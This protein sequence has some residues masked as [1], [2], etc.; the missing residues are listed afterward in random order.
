MQIVMIAN[1]TTF[2]FNL[3]RE[4]LAELVNQGHN[5]VVAGQALNFFDELEKM[6]CGIV[7]IH[8]PRRGKNPFADLKLYK[9]YYRMLKKNRPSLVFTNNIKPN[10]YAGLA[11]RQLKIPYIVNITGLG[12]AVETPGIMQKITTKLY[13]IGVS[14]AECVF[15]QN[16]QNEQF[17][18]ERKMLSKKS[19]IRLLPGSG[20]N[21]ES[22]PSLP[23]PKEDKIHFLFVA[24]ILKEKGIDQYLAAAEAI[25]KKRKDVVFH[26]C[27]GC[28]DPH[29]IQILNQAQENEIVE[30][31]GQQKDM[32]PFFEQAACIVHPSYYP[33]GMSNVLLEAAAGARP[34]IATNRSGCRETVDDGVS[35]Y[36]IPIKEQEPLVDALEAFLALSWE[37]RREMGRAGRRKMEAE[38]DRNLVVKAYLEEIDLMINKRKGRDA[39]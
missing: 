19:R 29:Y 9:E 39:E 8:T 31:H 3:R 24:R 12:T 26:I 36:I 25:R 23:Y 35:G 33:E 21:L 34:V 7:D 5:V 38:F 27:G 15:F 13:K 22:H 1:D 11:C 2:L 18:R 14:G 17:F 20:V 28:D 6:G 37:E 10:I 30:Y 4:V 32:L 16:S